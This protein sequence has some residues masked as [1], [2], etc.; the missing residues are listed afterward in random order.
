MSN[1]HAISKR[2]SLEMG[3]LESDLCEMKLKAIT[4]KNKNY[5]IIHPSK[6]GIKQGP[7]EGYSLR[8]KVDK[9]AA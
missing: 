2:W 9:T 4:Y 7:L 3:V 1:D 8:A 6:F 5:V